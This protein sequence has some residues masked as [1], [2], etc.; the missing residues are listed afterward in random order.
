VPRTEYC[1][2]AKKYKQ[3]QQHWSNNAYPCHRFISNALQPRLI[4]KRKTCWNDW[5]RKEGARYIRVDLGK[6]RD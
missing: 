1:V 6:A 2:Q 4:E 5:P 3:Q